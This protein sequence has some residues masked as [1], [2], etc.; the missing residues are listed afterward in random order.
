MGLIQVVQTIPMNL[1][2]RKPCSA[3]ASTIFE[4]HLHCTKVE[5]AAFI[6]ADLPFYF[7]GENQTSRTGT[8]SISKKNYPRYVWGVVLSAFYFILF[9]F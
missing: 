7:I 1:L 2:G 8:F 3:K 4:F 9:Y 5:L 6:Y